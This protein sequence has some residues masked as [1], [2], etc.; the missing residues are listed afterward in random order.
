MNFMK[1]KLLSI[2]LSFLMILSVFAPGLAGGAQHDFDITTADANTGVTMRG[3]INA[4]LQ[5]LA[6]LSSGA[7]AP[8]TPYAYQFWAD[9]TT[10]LL[11]IRN[12]ANNAWIIVGTLASANLGLSSVT[13]AYHSTYGSADLSTNSTTYVATSI[14]ITL[15]VGLSGKALISMNGTIATSGSSGGSNLRINMDGGVNYYP[16]Q[17]ATVSNSSYNG[18]MSLF[19]V[20]GLT[21]GNH[22]FSIE[23]ATTTGGTLTCNCSSDPAHYQLSIS[24]LSW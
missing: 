13:S 23:W 10:G 21:P 19:L 11:K 6:G 17:G 5:A 24:G 16:V 4:A 22:S 18:V 3:Q 8:V 2:A 9:T 14:I 15:Y 20:T 12:A 7:A 1:S